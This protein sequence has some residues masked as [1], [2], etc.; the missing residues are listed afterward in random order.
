MTKNLIVYLYKV[1]AFSSQ[2]NYLIMTFLFY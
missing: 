1:Q 2:C